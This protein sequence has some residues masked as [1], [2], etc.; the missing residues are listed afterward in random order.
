MPGSLVDLGATLRQ[1]R[2][3]NLAAIATGVPGVLVDQEFGV[4]PYSPVL[5]L[6]FVALPL[7]AMERAHRR[8]GVALIAGTTALLVLAAS[9]NPWWSDSMMPGKTLLLALP[10]LAPPLAHFY[11]KSADS[12][13]SRIWLQTILAL[14]LALTVA[15]VQHSRDIP[16]PQEGD[17]SSSVL[18]WLS[19]TWQL[20]NDAPTFTAGGSARAFAHAGLW[21]SAF[22][23]SWLAVSRIRSS[24]DRT[25]L[26]ATAMLLVVF[27]GGSAASAALVRGSSSRFDPEARVSLP[28][29]ESFSPV[30]RPIAVRYDPLSIVSPT[31][32]P[33]LFSLAAT[34][35]QRVDR[36]P[37]RVL[38]NARV[39]LPAGEYEVEVKGSG[40]P[41][42]AAPSAIGLQL[43]REGRPVQ[44]WRTSLGPGSSERFPVALPFD[45][46]FVGLRGSREV[47]QAVASLRW[48]VITVEPTSQ[49]HKVPT[50]LSAADFGPARIFFHDSGVYAERE[51]FW[52]RGRSTIRM[53]LVK[54]QDAVDSLTLAV[55]SGARANSATISSQGWEQRLELVPGVTQRIVVPARAGEHVASLSIATTDGFVPADVFPG[56]KDRRLLGVWVAFIPGDISRTSEV[57]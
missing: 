3:G 35:G 11:L 9:L 1:F 10:L 34:P 6:G 54:S 55:H 5:L 31:D 50:L 39:R 2:P 37:V 12:G 40:A 13:G 19:S 43:G 53:T 24:P 46:E 26:S 15:V 33:P 45:A 52:L 38:L 7:L 48:S 23:L 30:T 56:S 8:L 36:Q 28:L 16:L 47:E 14:S 21:L 32:L 51:G 4:F 18:Q 42:S 44:T 17:G 25:A 22:A 20:W 41:A 27:L 49:R 57:P 29:L